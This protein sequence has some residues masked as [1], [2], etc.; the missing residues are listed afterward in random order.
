M[1]LLSAGNNGQNHAL[2]LLRYFHSLFNNREKEVEII[3]SEALAHPVT[4]A[5]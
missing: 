5:F 2:M 1:E 3:L 4:N